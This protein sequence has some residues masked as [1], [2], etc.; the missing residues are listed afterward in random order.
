MSVF[1]FF[2]TSLAKLSKLMIN[3]ANKSKASGKTILITKSIR[4]KDKADEIARNIVLE[5]EEILILCLIN[6]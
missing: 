4:K 2:V 1:K 5:A 3:S 6:N